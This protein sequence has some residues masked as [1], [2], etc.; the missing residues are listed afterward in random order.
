M[1]NRHMSYTLPPH[2]AHYFG[3]YIR[4]LLRAV[5]EEHL[6]SYFLQVLFH[7]E[8]LEQRLKR[9]ENVAQT[10]AILSEV[11]RGGRNP[12]DLD[13]RLIDA[14]TELRV[15]DQIQKENFADI[16]KT[17]ETADLVASCEGKNYA[18]QVKHIRTTLTEHIGRLNANAARE[19]A[20]IRLRR[21]SNPVGTLRRIQF[22][23]VRPIRN[24]FW[25]SIDRKNA[26]FRNWQGDHV[27]CIA[28]VTNDPT[29]Q[30]GM[31][32]HLACQAVCAD[33]QFLQ[34]VNFDELL[35]LLDNGN[36]AWFKLNSHNRD[37]QCFVD[38]QDQPL[39]QRRIIDLDSPMPT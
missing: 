11:G 30:D 25:D 15:I 6:K 16:T 5:E 27:R 32:R 38:W 1:E 37:M 14:W 9:I 2:V 31:I 18:F 10:Q 23:F 24:L 4:R 19:Y 36:G 7:P 35:W 33:I 20:F 28:I 29:L 8:D 12:V 21:T 3:D 26:S 34:A 39:V 22:N 17:I 13:N